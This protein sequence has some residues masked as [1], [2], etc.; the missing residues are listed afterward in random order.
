MKI[1][2]Y[3]DDLLILAGCVLILIGVWRVCPVAVWF[4]S[5]GMLIVFGVLIGLGAKH[6]HS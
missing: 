3:V 4:V 6:D 1:K 5:G 2:N